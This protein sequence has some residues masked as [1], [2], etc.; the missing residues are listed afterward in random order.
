MLNYWHKINQSNYDIYVS[1]TQPLRTKGNK[2]DHSF[3]EI[4]FFHH[5]K[6]VV[7]KLKK[8]TLSSKKFNCGN[9][10][11]LDKTNIFQIVSFEIL[12]SSPSSLGITPEQPN[13][14][15]VKELILL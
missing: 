8:V 12:L 11:L 9:Y 5:P 1:R 14:L 7:L 15:T 10:I 2:C 13:S 6:M 4:N 3:I